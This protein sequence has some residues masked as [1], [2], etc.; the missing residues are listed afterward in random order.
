[1][2]GHSLAGLLAE[3][4]DRM[5]QAESEV[6]RLRDELDESRRRIDRLRDEVERYLAYFRGAA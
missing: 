2:S 6:Q 5:I 1:M 3:R 4:T